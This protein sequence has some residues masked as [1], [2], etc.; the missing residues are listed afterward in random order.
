[1]L[2]VLLTSTTTTEQSSSTSPP[3][4]TPTTT[5]EQSLDTTTPTTTT[6]G[7][8]TINSKAARIERLKER[9]AKLS[10]EDKQEYLQMKRERLETKKKYN[11]TI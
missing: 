7:S 1:M 2:V 8:S 4:T 10:P 9:L 6:Q 5:T 11:Q 3:T